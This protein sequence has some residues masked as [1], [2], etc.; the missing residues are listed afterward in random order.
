MTGVPDVAGFVG[1]FEGYLDL[2]IPNWIFYRF[3][4]SF[5]GN[6]NCPAGS[7]S[8]P[9]SDEY[10]YYNPYRQ[11]VARYHGF[12]GL[13]PSDADSIKFGLSTWSGCGVWEVPCSWG[14][15]SP[16]FDNVRVGVIHDA[17][18]PTVTL[19]EDQNFCDAFPEDGT[20]SITST[21]RVDIAYNLGGTECL[22]LGDSLYVYCPEDGICIELCFKVIPGPGV[23][24]ADPF[25]TSMFPGT[26][27]L[28]DT[29]LAVNPLSSSRCRATVCSRL[30]F[31]MAPPR[32][33]PSEP[34]R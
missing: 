22:N 30:A 33:F 2:P 16:A 11:C 32:K 26:Y 23:N 19:D 9:V 28:C 21:A 15:Q 6:P 12:S 18:G 34:S 27:A 24:L 4:V 8:P 7:W 1:T 29:S 10:V 3:H 13:V 14:N 20:N 17:I 5:V 25:F 31:S